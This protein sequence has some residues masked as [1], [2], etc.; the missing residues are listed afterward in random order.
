MDVDDVVDL[1]AALDDPGVGY[2]LDGGWGVDCLLGEQTRPHSDLDLVLP[3]ADLARVTTLLLSRGYVVIR[4]GLPTS[5]ALRD[6]S[7]REVDLHPVDLALRGARPRDDRRQERPMRLGARPGA[8][9]PGVRASPTGPR[10]RTA[11]LRRV[12]SRLAVDATVSR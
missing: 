8:H 5:V 2:W 7:G 10:R 12:R 11:S 1:L 6:G 9:A 4:D 3:R